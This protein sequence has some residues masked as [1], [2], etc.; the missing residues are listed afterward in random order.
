[1]RA[2]ADQTDPGESHWTHADP[3]GQP[4]RDQVISLKRMVTEARTRLGAGVTPEQVAAELRA[5]GID[6]T[7]DAVRGVWDG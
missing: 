4:P 1:M 3:A 5:R 6:T 2:K 7:A